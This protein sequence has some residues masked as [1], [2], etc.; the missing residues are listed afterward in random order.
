MNWTW[1]DIQQLENMIEDILQKDLH[2]LQG[3]TPNTRQGVARQIVYYLLKKYE[4][5]KK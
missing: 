1:E 5:E 3:D 2:E 4:L